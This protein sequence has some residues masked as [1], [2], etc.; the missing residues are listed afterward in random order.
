MS[1]PTNPG[2]EGK[3]E[4]YARMRISLTHLRVLTG[5]IHTNFLLCL[6][7]LSINVLFTLLKAFPRFQPV[8]KWIR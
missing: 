1:A 8:F 7:F 6:G 3:C 2:W 4:D 5:Y